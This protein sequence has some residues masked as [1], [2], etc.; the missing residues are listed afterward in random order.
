[1]SWPLCSANE[2][3]R[4][5]ERRHVLVAARKTDSNAL[6]RTSAF[7][8]NSNGR[9]GQDRQMVSAGGVKSPLAASRRCLCR[10]QRLEIAVA[11]DGLYR[12]GPEPHVE[13][14]QAAHRSGVSSV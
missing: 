2:E 4:T 14:H 11:R 9:V 1:M 10:I 8:V 12:I 7:S 6:T 13:P 3:A 5:N